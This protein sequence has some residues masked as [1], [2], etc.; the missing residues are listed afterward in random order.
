MKDNCLYSFR[1]VVEAAR[2]ALSDGHRWSLVQT[3]SVSVYDDGKRVGIL[4]IK[5]IIIKKIHT[6]RIT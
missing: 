1:F 4:K 5:I 6:V 2:R 3:L